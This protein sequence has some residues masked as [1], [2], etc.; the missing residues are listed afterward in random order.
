MYKKV[1]QIQSSYLFPESVSPFG[2]LTS[3]IEGPQV[4]AAE[5]PAPGPEEAPCTGACAGIGKDGIATANL[6]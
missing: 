2:L 4:T 3:V 6:P 5:V 1:N